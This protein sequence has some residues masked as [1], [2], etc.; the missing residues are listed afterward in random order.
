MSVE[1]IIR[2]WKD[3]DFRQSL[4]AAERARLPEHPAG[5]IDLTAAELDA[6]SGGVGHSHPGLSQEMGCE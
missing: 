1:Q 6:L 2:A 5:L 4:S 3:E